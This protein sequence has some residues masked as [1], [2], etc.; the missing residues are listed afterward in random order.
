[1]PPD[2]DKRFTEDF[3]R[4]WSRAGDDKKK[5]MSKNE[6]I[7][8]NQQEILKKDPRNHKIWFARGILL[9][10]MGRFKEALRC[11]DAVIKLDPRNKAVYNS[12]AS[13]LLQMGEIEQSSKWYRRALDMSSEEVAPEIRA[14]MSE[15]L[16][17]EEVIRE[18]IEESKE[19]EDTVRMRTCPICGSNVL[20]EAKICPTCEWEFHDEDYKELDFEEEDVKPDRELTEEEVRERLIDKIED[21]R[22]EGFEVSP[23]IRTLKTE[24]QRAKSA[25]AQFEENVAEIRKFKKNL[26]SLDTTGFDMKLKEMDQLFRSPYNMFAIRNEYDKLLKRI[27]AREAK[28]TGRPRRRI[29]REPTP[30]GLTNGQRGRVNDLGKDRPVG[31]T[32]GRKGRVNGM[33]NGRGRVNGLTNGMGHV[34]GM[35]NGVG[36]VNGMVNGR[37][38]VN[39]VTNGLIYRFQTMKTGLVNGLTNGNGIT[40]GLGS[41]RF[42]NESR[43]RKWKLAIVPIVALLLLTTPFFIYGDAPVSEITIDG[44]FDDWS[45]V[46]K[47]A[48]AR[49]LSVPPIPG[50][51]DIIGVAAKNDNRYL[52]LYAE[53]ITIALSGNPTT[54]IPDTVHFLLDVDSY[55]YTGY[56]VRGIGA[57]YM[58]RVMGHGG[59]AIRSQLFRFALGAEQ[60]NWSAWDA[61]GHPQAA[62][63]TNMLETQIPYKSLIGLGEKVSILVHTS[64]HDGYSDFAT[65]IISDQKGVLVVGQ[66]WTNQAD[67]L[68]LTGNTLL[69]MRARAL[70]AKMRLNSLTVN[71]TGDAS[72][73]EIERIRVLVSDAEV[74]AINSPTTDTLTFTFNGITVSE[75]DT[76]VIVID[77]TLKTQSGNTLGAKVSRS[78]DFELSSGVASLE[79]TYPEG[80]M[81]YIGPADTSQIKIDGG[82][83]DWN[84]AEID[85]DNVTVSNP[86]IDV[87]QFATKTVQRPFPSSR[88]DAHFYVNVAGRIAGGSLVPYASPGPLK[89]MIYVRDSDRDSV[90]DS[91]DIF[92]FD[93][94]NDEVL[95]VLTDSDVDGDQIQDYPVGS[96]YYLETT[97]PSGWPSPYGGREVRVYTGPRTVPTVTGEDYIRAFVDVDGNIGG[98]AIGPIYADY[99]LEIRGKNGEIGWISLMEF[100]GIATTDWEWT[101]TGKEVSA[102]LDMHRIEATADATEMGGSQFEVVFETSDWVG[103][104]D[105]TTNLSGRGRSA[106]RGSFGEYDARFTS[107]DYDA[108][109]TDQADKV[110]FRTVGNE[111]AWEIPRQVMWEDG[112]SEMVLGDLIPSDLVLSESEA[113]YP[114]AYSGLPISIEYAFE[115]GMLKENFVLDGPIAG[116]TA[117]G[118]LSLE[119]KMAYTDGL[120]VETSGTE[121]G[122][123][124]VINGGMQFKDRDRT[125]FSIESPYAMDA[126][127][128]TLD[129]HYLYNAERTLLDLR[130]PAEWFVN[131]EYPV[132]I[133]PT[134]STYTLENDGTLGQASERFG[135]SVAV[136]DFDNDGYADVLVG[137]PYSDANTSDSGAAY[138]YFGPFSASDTTPDVQIVAGNSGALLG[139]AVAAGK[140]NNDDYWDAAVSQKDNDAYVYYGASSWDPWVTSPDVTFDESSITDDTGVEGFGMSLA[141]GNFDDDGTPLN[142]DDLLIGA[143]FKN[144]GTGQPTS[145]PDGG[146]YA[147]VSVFASTETGEDHLLRPDDNKDKGHFGHSVAIGKIDSDDKFDVVVGEPFNNS[148]GSVQIFYGDEINTVSETPNEWLEPEQAGEKFG[149]SVAVGD[150]DTNS[151]ADIL[152]GAP[153]NDEGGTD[154]GRAYVYQSE[155]DGTGILAQSAP[156]LDLPGWGAGGMA[157][158]NVTVGDFYGDGQE[159][160]IVG[161]PYNQ[162]NSEGSV[163]IYDDPIGGDAVID[164]S[165]DGTQSDEHLGWS[166]AGGEFSNDIAFVLAGGAP[167]W[168]DGSPSET[169]AGRV[170]IMVIPENLE[171]I[172]FAPLLLAIPI[173]LK[174]RKRRSL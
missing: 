137:A 111:L 109:M 26:E 110:S 45:G 50:N 41:I 142:F 9:A 138:I 6:R 94:N 157:G 159:D 106:T 140:F 123:W 82:F 132:S 48:S 1:M 119:S 81:D 79:E 105:L 20:W 61:T 144:I 84:G 56:S 58:I 68:G 16:P 43:I 2:K 153:E 74:S 169:D 91:L 107:P 8:K 152:V 28:R 104:E 29:A 44:E 100:D 98:Y 73:T 166:V 170:M 174:R 93:F 54:E 51:I 25:V 66:F 33:V 17:A 155:T 13:A 116:L 125:S 4:K 101:N 97:I 23:I 127:G 143:P 10:E 173:G 150:M 24:P 80:F 88:I 53:V 171:M 52:S 112:T 121:S 15:Q 78:D 46:Q 5:P 158:Y 40:N 47:I 62:A 134:V 129:C 168:D 151:Y 39:G 22:L 57:D 128:D 70:G 64:S 139:W 141:A 86:N 147:F 59:A 124:A 149:W 95:D 60:S 120:M 114:D 21:Y 77:A 42:Q 83:S 160:A 65:N 14:T 90:P 148:D 99:L 87:S 163:F 27:E 161:A 3:V 63:S 76:V 72:P 19:W 146:V 118:Y 133:D 38:R 35:T 11:F 32:N 69:T 102:S 156:D 92:P 18:M 30:V 89:Q 34:N 7:L 75:D 31:L 12:K 108:Y 130:C 167:D 55:P 136:G 122:E 49:D 131:A 145:N 165:I 96:D 117:E 164:D 85:Q 115:N 37:G 71:L 135:Y 162:T 126:G 113:V 36:R 103:G 67:E 154:I 172:L